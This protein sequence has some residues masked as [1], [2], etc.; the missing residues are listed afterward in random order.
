MDRL[1]LRRGRIHIRAHGNVKI[2]NHGGRAG[3]DD[4]TLSVI[5]SSVGKNA[6]VEMKGKREYRVLDGY[7]PI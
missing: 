1:T 5:Q 6:I 2:V 3:Y 7:D 4:E